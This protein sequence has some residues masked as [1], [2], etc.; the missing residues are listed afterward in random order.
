MNYN[1]ATI[2]LTP[3]AFK[4]GKLYAVKGTD[5]TCVRATTAN[6][7]NSSGATQTMGVNVPLIDYSVAGCP[8]IDVR[9][10]DTI[11]EVIPTGVTRV[12]LNKE[13]GTTTYVAVTAGATYTIPVGRYDSILFDNGT[14]PVT[15]EFLLL[16]NNS[17]I[18]QED[19]SKII[20]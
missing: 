8:V 4:V 18:L 7:I 13:D 2:V 19:N 9:S 6:R 17:K 14:I 11:T 15:T 16:E 1:D 5:A 3:N 20:L 10:A 12:V